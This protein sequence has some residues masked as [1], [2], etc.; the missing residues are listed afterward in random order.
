[1]DNG[2]N[3]NRLALPDVADDVRVEVPETIPAVQK[4]VVIMSDAWRL[5]KALKG[6]VD[7]GPQSFCSVGAVLSDVKKDFAEVGFGFQ[8]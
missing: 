4:L 1:M 5:P 2:D 8:R 3:L 6:G 7:F